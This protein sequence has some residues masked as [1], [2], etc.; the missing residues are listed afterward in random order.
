MTV[1]PRLRCS[2]CGA[3]EGIRRRPGAGRRGLRRR[4]GR[5]L[6]LVG[7]NGAGQ[8]DAHQG[9]R[10]ASIRSTRARSCSRAARSTSTDPRTPPRWAS[11]SSTRTS[12]CATTSMWSRTCSSGARRPTGRLVAGRGRHGEARPGDAATACRCDD[13]GGAPDR[14]RRC[15]AASAS[16]SPSPGGA[17]EPQVWCSSTSRRPP[18]AWPRREQVL[19]LVRRLAEQGARRRAHL[20]QPERRLQGRRP[21]HRA[22]PRARCRPTSTDEGQPAAGGRG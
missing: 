14:S 22:A 4:C 1:A 16:R 9:D 20:A 19:D 15:P 10:R 21:N 8:V 12:R 6:A 18:S 11:R 5:G 13:P 17:V 2:R 7:D 3:S